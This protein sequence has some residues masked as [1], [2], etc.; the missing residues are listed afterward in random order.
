MPVQCAAGCRLMQG[1]VGLALFTPLALAVRR[2]LPATVV[3]HGAMVFAQ[4]I[5]GAGTV[6]VGGDMAA[7]PIDPVVFALI[8]EALAGLVLG[9]AAA[10]LERTLPERRDLPR[11]FACGVAVWATNLLFIFGVQMV[12]KANAAAVGTLMQPCLPIVATLLSIMLGYERS[13]PSK[14]GGIGVA[15][16][17]STIVVA[18]GEFENNSAPSTGGVTDKALLTQGTLTLLA[19]AFTNASYILLQRKLLQPPRNFPVLTLTA[20]G[21][22]VAAVC[23]LMF[24]T[25][26]PGW[27]S[28][29]DEG[30]WNLPEEAWLPI[31]YWVFAGS[32]VGY[33]CNSFANTVLFPSILTAYQCLQPLVGVVFA[34]LLLDEPLAWRDAAGLLII[35]GL[36]VTSF[37]AKKEDAL[38]HR[39]EGSCDSNSSDEPLLEH[40]VSTAP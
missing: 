33:S 13:T 11:V 17:G 30:G 21:F 37:G 40:E 35:A 9:I 34:F 5:F 26:T 28:S 18:L 39:A 20:C 23:M 31:A 6:L 25:I 19:Q 38:L 7:H 14:L 12:S 36:F 22:L 29:T 4:V 3:A 15:I 1:V 16:L 10:A 32:C 8:R 2:W 27:N 24:S